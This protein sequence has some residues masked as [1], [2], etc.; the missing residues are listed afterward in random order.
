MLLQ[1]VVVVEVVLLLLLLLLLRER[2][3]KLQTG[4]EMTATSAPEKF[5]KNNVVRVAKTFFV[6]EEGGR[7]QGVVKTPE[8]YDTRQ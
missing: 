4:G 3:D 1:L 7:E 5:N 6:E 8:R 2:K